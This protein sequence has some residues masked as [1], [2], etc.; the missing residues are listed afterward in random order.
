MRF[1]EGPRVPTVV[2]AID[3]TV[4]ICHPNVPEDL[5]PCRINRDNLRRPMKRTFCLIEVD[6]ACYV[7]GDSR[8][9]VTRFR[10][11]VYLDG[12]R[13]G[14]AHLVQLMGECDCLRS[15]PTVPVDNDCGSLFLEGVRKANVVGIEEA[16]NPVKHLSPMMVAID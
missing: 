5:C 13:H 1:V 14:N 8:G 16:H 4:F 2:V 10:N 7:R 9:L 11:R 15:T 6:C 12:E 3:W